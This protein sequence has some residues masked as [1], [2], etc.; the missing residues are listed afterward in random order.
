MHL[1]DDIVS[2]KMEDKRDDFDFEIVK[3]PFLDGDVARST[4]YEVYTSQLIRF[5][6]NGK[7]DMST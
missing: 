2:A 4:S 6:T 3:F 5:C 1:T 7:S